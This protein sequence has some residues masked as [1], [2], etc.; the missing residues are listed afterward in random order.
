MCESGSFECFDG[1]ITAENRL[2]DLDCL[3][4]GASGIPDR[5]SIL[6]RLTR[7]KVS[8]AHQAAQLDLKCLVGYHRC[9]P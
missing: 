3:K 2:Q 9:R 8:N 1:C 7:L 6:T 4:E 5:M